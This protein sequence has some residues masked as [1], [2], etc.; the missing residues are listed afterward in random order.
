[1]SAPFGP[2]GP[3]AVLAGPDP[4]A[5]MESTPTHRPD[6]RGPDAGGVRP[7]RVLLVR[8][9]RVKQAISTARVQFGEPV[10]L[11][12]VYAL[13]AGEHEV[14]IL[15]LMVPGE[16]LMPVLARF[17]PDVVGLTTLCIDVDAVLALSR[18][19]KA[20]RPET[21]VLVGG[22]QTW[23]GPEPFF[24]PSVDHVFRWTDRDNLP[25]LFAHLDDGPDQPRIDG[26][27]S[28]VHSFQTTP[29]RGRN[30]LMEPNRRSTARYRHL[31]NYFG[32][33]PAALM[34]TSHGCSAHCDFCMRWRLEGGREQPLPVDEVADNIAA[35]QEPTVM[36]Y[37]NDLVHDGARL[38]ALCDALEARGIQ[39][40]FICYASVAGLLRN[41]EVVARFARLGLR[42]VLVGYESF[43]DAD[44][45]AY[46]KPSPVAD[47]YRAADLLRELGVA[48]WASFIL[49][50]DWGAEDFVA[51][52]RALRRLRPQTTSLV[53]LT[54]FPGLPIHTRFAD[55]L[56]VGSG[57]HRA[58]DF[59]RVLI[60]PS[61]LSVRRYYFE[62]VKTNLF[63]S[64]WLDSAPYMLRQ[65]G[66]GT[67]LRI[68]W[69]SSGLLLIYLKLWL[70]APDAP[71]LPLEGDGA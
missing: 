39:K 56:L 49:H 2:S 64:I 41:R 36:F 66:L 34:Q 28:R 40:N 32:Y 53:P 4:K 30:V 43:S 19:V 33:R 23:F 16:A 31:Y 1:M 70:T 10:G 29:K 20:W 51:L 54:P 71:Y 55:R 18:Q 13:L 17:Q 21:V 60:R 35:V 42:A 69:G 65:F 68:L 45:T 38:S 57:N 48:C 46:R 24:V 67:F 12:I 25:R 3:R 63:I 44:L 50:P 62:I 8:P 61:K 15:D 27:H 26:V 37:D 58:W 9:P 5:D 22:T 14:E 6:P 11:E 7:R 52:R 59:G 47:S